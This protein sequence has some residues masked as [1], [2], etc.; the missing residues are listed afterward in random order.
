VP[1]LAFVET[2]LS[3]SGF[4]AIKYARAQGADVLFLTRDP[5]YYPC[6]GALDPRA[7][8]EISE[9]V[10]CETN[11]VAKIVAELAP[12][13][14]AAVLAAG[15]YHVEYAARV[16]REL[17]VCGLS[18]SAA[19][20]ARNKRLCYATCAAAGIRVPAH[21]TARTEAK[22]VE[23]ADWL[24]Y[25]CVIKPVDGTAS[26]A[27]RFC[28]SPEDVA[29]AAVPIL[30]AARNPRGQRCAQEI[31]VAEYLTGPE[32]SV[33]TLSSGGITTVYGV[34]DKHLAA[35][36]YFVETGHTFPSAWPETVTNDC[37]RV[38]CEALKAIGF[39]TGMAH[40]ELKLTAAGPVLLEINARP[41]GD[42]ITELIRLAT[43]VDP[44]EAW[45]RAMLGQPVC[46]MPPARR[47]A[48]IRYLTP[49]AGRVM[50]VTGQA[51]LRDIPGV[52]EISVRVS[53]GDVTVLPRSSHDRSG[54]VIAVG[55]EPVLAERTAETAAG[56]ILVRVEP[57]GK[58]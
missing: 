28:M 27:V 55:D 12:R 42:H 15:E 41:P 35:L 52:A 50:Q 10:V 48:A 23:I 16:A 38:T 3:G 17:K 39:D 29:A 14:V 57:A 18:P 25:P 43:G 54:Y 26:A 51:Q 46:A 31:M 32:T 30:G 11:D 53:A 4:I 33:E 49:P 40:T 13:G 7:I 9:L 5:G 6:H 58:I 22:A 45:M 34:T 19:Q 1:L 47:A 21:A 2:S 24:G 56:R 37:I 36:P 44:L 20:V 8:P